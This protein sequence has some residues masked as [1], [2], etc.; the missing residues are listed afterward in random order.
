[1]RKKM[2]TNTFQKERAYFLHKINNISA[3]G[4]MWAI[5]AQDEEFKIVIYLVLLKLFDNGY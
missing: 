4:A 1:M 3:P 5:T 2:N